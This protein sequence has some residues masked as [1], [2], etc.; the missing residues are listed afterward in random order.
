MKLEV[1]E[2]CTG[3]GTCVRDCPVGA[4]MVKDG[5]VAARKPEECIDCKHCVAVC[6]V[7][8]IAVNGV[9]AADC[10]AIG[11]TPDP[12][13]VRNLIRQ[14][15]SI[16]QYAAEELAKAEIAEL[17]ATL[18]YAPTGCNARATRFIVIDSR[19]KM[20]EIKTKLVEL[21]KSKFKDL[22]EF[23]RG[24]VIAVTKKPEADPFFRGAPH[25]LIVEAGEG[26]VTP[27]EDC[28]AAC[29]YFDVLAQGC[30]YGTTWCG[31]LKMI[32]DA[33]PEAASLFGLASGR[34]FY[35][36]LFGRAAVSYPRNV[37][38]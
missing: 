30:G 37:V 9:G 35:A 19:A 31:F 14:R 29:A 7:G 38:R 2:N 26:A 20:A 6:P 13:E 36:M 33:V 15:R 34:P 16:R 10:G 25:L 28:V 11:K 21:L 4:L 18:D 27:Y 23:L 32:V 5:K 8:A 17:V 12:E 22:P 24:P 1:S 3:C